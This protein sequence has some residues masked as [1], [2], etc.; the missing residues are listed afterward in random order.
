MS[1][2]LLL[3]RHGQTDFSLANK[4]C[5]SI[6]P[7]L[8]QTGLAMADALGARYGHA[9]LAAIFASPKLRTRQTAAPT[10][11]AAG[12]EVQL[13]EGL[14]EIA[15]GEWEGRPEAE[16]EKAEPERFHAWAEHPGKVSP[17]GGETAVEIAAR[18]LQAIE[19]IRALHSDGKVLVV[20]HKA[21][22]RVLIC[23]LLGVDVDL[24]RA[25][26]AQP[27]G[28]VSSVTFKKSGPLLERLGDTSHLPPDLLG[29]DGT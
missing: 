27:V 7:P 12:L 8:N 25:R 5:G 20:S 17:P 19:R 10:A 21:T 1:L 11:A 16:V 24:F 13:D 23:A 9:G 29:L 26:I 18:A 14:R 3:V 15:Y 28:A 22:I 4:F 6:D 2:T